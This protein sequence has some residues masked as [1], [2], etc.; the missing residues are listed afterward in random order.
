LT[1]LIRVNSRLDPFLL[2]AHGAIHVFLTKFAFFKPL[3][4]YKN[5]NEQVLKTALFR[6]LETGVD[7]IMT[8]YP[9]LVSSVLNEWKSSH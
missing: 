3:I 5:M 2:K 7:G 8:D 4:K 6:L 9:V 1:V